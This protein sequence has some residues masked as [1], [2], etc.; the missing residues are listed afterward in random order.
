MLQEKPGCYVFLG[1][2]MD[3]GPGGCSIHNVNYDFNDEVAITGS[4]YWARLVETLLPA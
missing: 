2:G 3:G 4:S 1:N